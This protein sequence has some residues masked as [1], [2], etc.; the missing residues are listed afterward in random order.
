MSDRLTPVSGQDTLER[1]QRNERRAQ[2]R[3]LDSRLRHYDALALTQGSSGND[4]VNVDFY[5]PLPEP[6]DLTAETGGES[7]PTNRVAPQTPRV[8]TRPEPV[9]STTPTTSGATRPISGSWRIVVRESAELVFIR[10][11]PGQCQEWLTASETTS[12]E[13]EIFHT[14]ETP[15]PLQLEF[16][17]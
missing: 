11:L 10:H 8:I 5:P 1:T 17:S 13:W 14:Q 15:D 3:R 12:G 7:S 9:L 2:Q 6:V 4:S 16:P